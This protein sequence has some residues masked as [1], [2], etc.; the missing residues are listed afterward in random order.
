MSD[1]LFEIGD[2]VFNG[3]SGTCGEVL[4]SSD[5]SVE[6]MWDNGDRQAYHK[7]NIERLGIESTGLRYAPEL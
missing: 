1:R 7:E 4:H 2:R 5:G 6:V 3:K